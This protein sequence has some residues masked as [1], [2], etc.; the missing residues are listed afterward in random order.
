MMM[1][2]PIS[3]THDD[4]PLF[5]Q[6]VEYPTGQ[7]VWVSRI[8]HDIQHV[9]MLAPKSYLIA[10]L[11]H[12]IRI[13]RT[14]VSCTVQILQEVTGFQ[15]KNKSLEFW[16][17]NGLQHYITTFSRCK[18]I[19]NCNI[20]AMWMNFKLWYNVKSSKQYETF[21]VAQLP[22]FLRLKKK[23]KNNWHTKAMPKLTS[24]G[25]V[26]WCWHIE[27]HHHYYP[28]HSPNHYPNLLNLHSLH[29]LQLASTWRKEN[30]YKFLPLWQAAIS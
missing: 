20:L 13:L 8:K 16:I 15:N 5:Q 30:Y 2:C 6:Q 29:H 17:C 3:L 14:L 27:F 26:L 28:C 9:F 23:W 24:S 11:K 10:T 25:N 1:Q 22:P 12:S 21:L 4:A 19:W 18:S 7:C